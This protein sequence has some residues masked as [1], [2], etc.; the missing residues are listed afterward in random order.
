MQPPARS[1]VRP[2][3][4][5]PLSR[6]LKKL[7]I[8]LLSHVVVPL[9]RSYMALVAATSRV[10]LSAA[11]ALFGARR[12]GAVVVCAILH[13]DVFALP[14]L[15]RGRRIVTFVNLSDAGQVIARI[16]E[17]L[18]FLVERGGSS[19]RVS[20]L[21]PV[22]GRLVARARAEAPAG[23][24]LFAFACDGSRGPAGAVKGGTALFALRTGAA[25]YVAKLAARPALYLPTW[26]R[27]LV[28]LPFSR[29]R[30]LVEGPI[31]LPHGPL[32]QTLEP[33]RRSIEHRLHWLHTTAFAGGRPRP[34]RLTPLAEAP[35]AF[36]RGRGAG[37]PP[38]HRRPKARR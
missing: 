31:A 6:R 34:A 36:R 33:L 17:T 20:R 4:P 10:D 1:T 26:D 13:Q 38:G 14:Y 22:L 29:I 2:A 16:L 18:G 15:L 5:L 25:V 3:R 7:G 32:R 9:Y 30:L 24:V 35:P 12:P 28:P 23:G 19:T 8:A 37:P 21:V 27:T 11:A